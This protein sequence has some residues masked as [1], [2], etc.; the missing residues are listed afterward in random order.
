MSL[1]L[2][3]QIQRQTKE[4]SSRY[5]PNSGAIFR[6]CYIEISNKTLFFMHQNE[7][8]KEEKTL[9][10]HACT[11][12]KIF[13]VRLQLQIVVPLYTT[14]NLKLCVAH[15]SISPPRWSVKYLL[16]C[17]YKAKLSLIILISSCQNQSLCYHG[18]T[19]DQLD[20]QFHGF[21]KNIYKND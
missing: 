19:F 8:K 3:K 20:W 16:T 4:M 17:L 13:S 15:A 18:T 6:F 1:I 2:L 11:K 21:K 9:K 10:R 12:G 14:V 7:R 5:A